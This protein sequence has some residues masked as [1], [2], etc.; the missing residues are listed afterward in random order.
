MDGTELA[1]IGVPFANGQSAALAVALNRGGIFSGGGKL[2]LTRYFDGTL[3]SFSAVP[4]THEPD[5]MVR[6]PMFFPLDRPEQPVDTL[7]G[8]IYIT[9]IDARETRV[10]AYA[11]PLLF[12]QSEGKENVDWSCESGGSEHY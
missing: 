5:H 3:M 12:P 4:G 7:D 8:H 1:P 11:N 6:L 10:R 2:W 9:D